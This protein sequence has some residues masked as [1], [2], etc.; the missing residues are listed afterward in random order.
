MQ[1]GKNMMINR[2]RMMWFSLLGVLCVSSLYF[3]FHNH[4]LYE[5]TIGE[6]TSVTT[7]NQ[8]NTID[9]YEN[10]DTLYTQQLTLT[11][12]NGA[13]EGQEVIAENGY[14]TSQANDY[15]LKKGTELFVTMKEA[16]DGTQSATIDGVKRDKYLAIIV[17]M[18]LLMLIVVS[19]KQGVFAI[20]TLCTNAFILSYA[21]DLYIANEQASLL[22]I[23]S[24]C[25]LIFTIFSLLVVNGVN[26]KTAAAIIATLIGTAVSLAITFLVLKLTNEQGLYYEELQFLTRPYKTVFFAGLFLG[27]LGAVMDVAIT[28]SSSLVT[29]YEEHPTI[30]IK[31][32]TQSGLEIGRDIMGTMTNILFFAYIS[33]AIPMLI[34]YFK[35]AGAFGYTLSINLSLE[36]VRALAGGIG[37]VVTIPVSLY[38]TIF[39][40]LKSKKVTE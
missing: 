10:E 34:L 21:L 39:F 16:K 31:A 1:V 5:Q 38:V 30:S 23:C 40:I 28:I 35:N 32:L 8:E 29:L 14:S 4:A 2:K 3:V 6:V 13:H 22:F 19:K 9:Q 37:I 7:L 33:G 11:L 27:A 17:W 12:K 25:I 15:E 24:I 20:V 26:K 36:I 18:L